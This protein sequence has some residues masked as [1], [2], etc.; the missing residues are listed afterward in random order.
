MCADILAWQIGHPPE[1]MHPTEWRERLISLNLPEREPSDHHVL[2]AGMLA[3]VLRYESPAD[4]AWWLW[5]AKPARLPKC[6]CRPKVVRLRLERSVIE[7]S[8]PP[9]KVLAVLALL[10]LADMGGPDAR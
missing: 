5:Q 8:V 6:T 10:G 3:W 1:D 4:A 2:S 9:E 7:V